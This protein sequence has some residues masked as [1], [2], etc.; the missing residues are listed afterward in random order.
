MFYGYLRQ[1]VLGRKRFITLPLHH[2][3]HTP[4]ET[5]KDFRPDHQGFVWID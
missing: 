3:Q 5:A 1:K 2:I 4:D